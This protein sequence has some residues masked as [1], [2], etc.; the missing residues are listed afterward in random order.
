[1]PKKINIESV[2]DIKSDENNNIEIEYMTEPK[3]HKA[4]KAKEKEAEK[5]KKEEKSKDKE[6]EIARLNRELKKYK[7]EY[8]RQVADKENLR[9]RLER[10]KSEFYQYALSSF[11]QDFLEV[12]DNF[13]RALESHKETDCPD[14]KSGIQM[15]YKQLLDLL[16]KQGVRPI[17][18]RDKKFDPNFHQAFIIEESNEVDEPQVSQELQKGYRLHDRLIRPSLVKVIMPKKEQQ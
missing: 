6:E 9:K 8:L 4:D 3:K 11:I 7:E 2:S 17:E 5:E 18:I 14:L 12:L 16:T 10:E 13:E 1:M 15:I